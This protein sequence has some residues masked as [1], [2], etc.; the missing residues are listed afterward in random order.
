MVGSLSRSLTRLRGLAL[1]IG[2][3]ASIGIV[4][5][6]GASAAAPPPIRHVFVIVLENKEFLEW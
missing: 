4:G 3:A 2:L 1:L 5:A 6:P